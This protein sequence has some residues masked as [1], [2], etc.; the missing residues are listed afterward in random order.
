MHYTF[1]LKDVGKRNDEMRSE[2]E[3]VDE[4]GVS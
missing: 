3:G 1:T 2:A 4:K